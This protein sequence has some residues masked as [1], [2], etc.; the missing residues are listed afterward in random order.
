MLSYLNPQTVSF[1]LSDPGA[2]VSL[3]VWQVPAQVTKIEILEASVLTAD[4]LAAGTV[5]GMSVQLLDGGAAGAGTGAITDIIGAVAAGT[6]PA[7]TAVTP[8]AF[9]IS[10]GTLDAGDWVVVKYDETG[11]VAESNIVI[12]FTYVSGIGA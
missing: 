10:E 4:G 7:W 12:W 1:S 6:H 9:S 11:T 5:N 2:D 3:P 8:Q